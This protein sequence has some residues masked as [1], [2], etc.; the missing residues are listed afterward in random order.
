MDNKKLL[1]TLEKIKNGN[2]LYLDID[3]N[4]VLNPLAFAKIY[5]YITDKESVDESLQEQPAPIDSKR[6]LELEDI[7]SF[8]IQI[9]QDIEL[10]AKCPMIGYI[11]LKKLDWAIKNAFKLIWDAAYNDFD[12]WMKGVYKKLKF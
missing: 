10:W 3:G 1:E 4:I 12:N 2:P 9:A 8:I 5:K 7:W 6:E 11:E